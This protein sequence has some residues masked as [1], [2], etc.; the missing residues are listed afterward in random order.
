MSKALFVRK[1]TGLVREVGPFTA[2]TICLSHVIGGGI[3]FYS[4]NA[5]VSFPGAN[6]PLGYG[7]AGIPTVLVA[8]VVALMGISM[9]RAGGDYVFMSRVLS[10]PM[11]FL[12]SWLFWGTEV[13]SLGIIGFLD[14]WFWGLGLWVVGKAMNAPGI[15]ALGLALQDETIS[16]IGGLI[17]VA[18]MSLIAILGMRIYS[19]FINI[20]WVI[21]AVGSFITLGYFG[22][23]MVGANA[24]AAWD[25]VFGAGV[26]DKVVSFAET[27]GWSEA[28]YGFG[29]D[30]SATFYTMIPA[31]W[32]YIGFTSPAFVGSEVRDPPR[33]ML[34]G[35][36][37]GSIVIAIYYVIISALCYGAYGNFVS[38][39]GFAAAQPGFE[40]AVG[41]PALEP[42][43]P[44]FGGVLAMDV[45][46]LAFFIAVTGAIWLM[47]DIP[48][49]LLV[50]SRQVFA[51]AF[52][53]QF[54]E[55]F[56]AVSERWHSPHY[57]ILLT[58]VLG[59]VGVIMSHSAIFGAV[60]MMIDTTMLAVFRYMIVSITGMVIPYV[61]PEIWER[62]LKWMFL[63][64]PVIT[65]AGLLGLSIWSFIFFYGMT[66][67]DVATAAGLG[68]VIFFA[69][70]FAS[71]ML[72]FNGYYAYNIKR[73]I[74]VKTL[75]REVPPA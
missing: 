2:F 16:V 39:Y 29:I 28:Q 75:F 35:V 72:I 8:L 49:F 59:F 43:L 58:M 7:L 13:L 31:T 9:P 44:L 19:W 61:R 45:P 25:N 60:V 52:D 55:T 57:A 20:L 15:I 34:M 40:A 69:A 71:G 32:A 10:P 56:A 70:W 24:Q 4:I 73:G 46:V 26:W 64:L 68:T 48:P 6:V 37:L 11:G 67:I 3:N 21:P 53:R 27:S 62:G 36:A 22:G 5:S 66:G 50:C 51:W 18:V 30:M 41:M 74:D 12:T 65:I 1:A 38:A 17:L 14:I 23:A 47:N 42:M 54:P 63:G 33:G